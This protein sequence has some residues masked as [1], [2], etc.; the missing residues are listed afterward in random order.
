MIS[1]SSRTRTVASSFRFVALRSGSTLFYLKYVVGDDGTSTFLGL[2][3]STVFLTSG[4]IGLVLGTACL[5]SIARKID[6]KYYATA[7]SVITGVCFVSFFLLPK[8]RYGL[9]LGLNVV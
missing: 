9:M 3:G 2:D 1:P 6:K 7:L 8:D 5:G 4:S